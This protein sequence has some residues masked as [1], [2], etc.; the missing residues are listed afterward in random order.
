MAENSAQEAL[1]EFLEKRWWVLALRGALGIVFGIICFTS[2]AIAALSLLFVFGAFALVDGILGV[3][4]SFGRARRG[5]RWV[6]LAVEAVASIIIGM[7]VLTMPAISMVVLFLVIAIKALVSG[8]LLLFASI[9]LDG[10][11]GQG[12]LIA[13]ALFNLAFAALMFLAPLLGAKIL[14][15]W[16]GIWAILFGVALLA[17]GF[18]LKGAASKLAAS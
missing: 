10:E 5:E 7:L 4:S 16:I 9:K 11:H 12:W 14:V 8:V 1:Q 18:K 3:V 13:A 2:P 17:V 15:W 6:W